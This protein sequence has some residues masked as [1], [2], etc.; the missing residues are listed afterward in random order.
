MKNIKNVLIATTRQF[1]CGDE[2][3]LMGT[4]ALLKSI[5][6]DFNT[7]I[8][9]RNPELLHRTDRYIFN[10]QIN[11][12]RFRFKALKPAGYFD[13]SF[14]EEL[15]PEPFIDLAVFAGTPGWAGARMK[16]FYEYLDRHHTPSVFL[17]IGS[18]DNELDITK[19]PGLYQR[20]IKNARLITTRD[21]VTTNALAAY[22]AHYLPCPAFLAAR[23]SVERKINEVKKIGLIYEAHR[24]S[25]H[26]RVS[27]ESHVFILGL[28][29]KLLSEYGK[30]FE[31][32]FVCHY[33]N[34]IPQCLKDFP[35][36]E[37]R[38]SYDAAD[39]IYIY[40]KFD[41]VIGPRVHG[42]GLAASLGI[43]GISILHDA[44]GD[45]CRGFGADV[46]LVGSDMDTFFSLLKSKIEHIADENIS[47]L[48]KKEKVFA[49]YKALLTPILN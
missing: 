24:S 42:I 41:L 1:N 21:E 36:M 48:Q 40:R 7:V 5:I 20:A 8:F 23:Q 27:Q 12:Q 9:N 19:F 26:N 4:R 13:N 46:I 35:G 29:K 28:Y 44:R 3:I 22:N 49:E 2:F 6:G 37:C 10:F 45:T 25:K 15:L 16:I 43:P 34:E 38:Y 30:N 33:V 17:G 47:L 32:E 11:F 39:Y 14:K 18:G 31:F